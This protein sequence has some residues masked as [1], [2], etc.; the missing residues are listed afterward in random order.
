MAM[1]ASVIDC[2]LLLVRALIK[3]L[4]QDPEDLEVW[5]HQSTANFPDWDLSLEESHHRLIPMTT[6][7]ATDQC[8]GQRE[9]I[10]L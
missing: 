9:T 10:H 8:I 4:Y 2:L 1:V 7:T 5:C 3:S 6:T